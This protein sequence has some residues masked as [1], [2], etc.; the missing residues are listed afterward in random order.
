MN[1]SLAILSMKELLDTYG[2]GIMVREGTGSRNP[3]GKFLLLAG[4]F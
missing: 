4:Y 2:L 3:E 1:S